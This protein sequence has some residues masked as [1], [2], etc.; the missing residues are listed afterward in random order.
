MIWIF[1]PSFNS[2][3][4]LH[5]NQYNNI[6][7]ISMANTFW[8][9][10]ASTSSAFVMSSLLKNGKFSIEDIQNATFAGGIMIA[11]TADMYAFPFPSLIVGVIAGSMSCAS[12]H[13]LPK[14]LVNIKYFDTRGILYLHG[15]PGIFAAVISSITC[16]TLGQN[17]FGTGSM[18]SNTM[19]FDRS[20]VTQ[21]GYQFAG[22]LISLL[23][24]CASG[25]VMGFILRIWR[26]LDLPVDTFGDHIWWKMIQ[27]TNPEPYVQ[28]VKD[29]ATVVANPRGIG[30]VIEIP[31][32]S[33]KLKIE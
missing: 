19:L 8:A 26:L 11:A 2:V 5:L 28:N 17:Y 29:V 3:N 24:G 6:R 9:L 23:M 31:V 21:G 12:F 27:L 7:Y 14:L 18:I 15:I 32:R 22:M 25:A 20:P 30:E 1:F 16:A 13:F 33:R 4:P 10:A